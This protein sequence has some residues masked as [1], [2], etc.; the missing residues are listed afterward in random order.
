M[1]KTAIKR[2]VVLNC[3]FLSVALFS[4]FIGVVD[5]HSRYL[6][7]KETIAVLDSKLQQLCDE[8]NRSL[9]GL[10][11][12]ERLVYKSTALARHLPQFDSILETVYRI[13]PK[14]GFNP[15][16]VLKIIQVESAFKPNAVSSRGAYGLMQVN[17]AVWQEELHIDKKKIF[18]VEYN[19]DL[20]LRILKHYY[21]LTKGDIKLALHHY[22]NGYQYNNRAYVKNFPKQL[23]EHHLPIQPSYFQAQMP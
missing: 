10:L 18:D 8:H 9:E 21:D 13:A 22:N 1:F 11:G 23:L 5:L 3:L 20:G 4:F 6:N 16:L 7:Q 19:I 17:L 14:Y 12:Q 15:E 2:I